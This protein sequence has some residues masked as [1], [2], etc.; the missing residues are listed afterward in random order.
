MS[1]QLVARAL[2]ALQSGRVA[3]QPE[4]CNGLAMIGGQLA[5]LISRIDAQY[6]EGYDD[7]GGFIAHDFSGYLF[8]PYCLGSSAYDGH[9]PDCHHWNTRVAL[10]NLC[11]DIL[12]EQE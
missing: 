12:G 10:L 8:C 5:E 3:Y 9:T 7:G 1:N 2:K 4:D 6:P 11:R